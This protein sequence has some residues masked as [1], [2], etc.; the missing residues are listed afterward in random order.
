MCWRPVMICKIRLKIRLTKP[1]HSAY[2]SLLH[3]MFS[4]LRHLTLE[5]W[6]CISFMNSSSW[7]QKPSN[8]LTSRLMFPNWTIRIPLDCMMYNH[9]SSHVNHISSCQLSYATDFTMSRKIQIQ[10]Q[11]PV[12]DGGRIQTCTF[13]WTRCRT[14]AKQKQ[15][16]SSSSQ[17]LAVT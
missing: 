15:T 5:R 8:N 9:I 7:I 11:A 4:S 6:C 10:R 1:K 14:S 3:L 13:Y 16:K 12:F 17:L 2:I